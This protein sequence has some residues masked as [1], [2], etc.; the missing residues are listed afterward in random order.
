MFGLGSY[1]EILGYRLQRG[2]REPRAHT[3]R[4]RY[5]GRLRPVEKRDGKAAGKS[6]AG[7]GGVGHG[8]IQPEGEGIAMSDDLDIME[9]SPQATIT[10]EFV[11]RRVLDWKNR[12]HALFQEVQTWAKENGWRVE[13]N[14][15]VQM[16]EELMQKYDVPETEQP[17][18][19][20]DREDSFALF[21]PKALW[22]IGAN[23]RIDLYTSKSLFV[24]VDLAED[25]Q[26]PRW[27]IFRASQ[28]R[29]GDPF[30]PE[31]IANLV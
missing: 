2:L 29:G 27:T 23:G 7:G 10:K 22:V 31:M 4:A 24:I 5:S 19:R 3:A 30:K 15:S 14:G 9:E 28:N 1:S 18:L 25:D 8:P 12:L 21:M 20:L 6:Q 11:E 17:T 26:I 13:D 16:H